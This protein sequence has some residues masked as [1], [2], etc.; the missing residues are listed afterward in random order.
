V[1]V[2]VLVDVTGRAQVRIAHDA[3]DARKPG[4]QHINNNHP[5]A[6]AKHTQTPHAGTDPLRPSSARLI[7]QTSTAS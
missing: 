5:D 4:L 7:M 6:P 1:P 3:Q 2:P